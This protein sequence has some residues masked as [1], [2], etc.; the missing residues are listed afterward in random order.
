MRLDAVNQALGRRHIA[1]T[2]SIWAIF[3]DSRRRIHHRL[4][5]RI[6]E[7]LLRMHVLAKD[8]TA[9][10]AQQE[11]FNCGD[12]KKFGFRVKKGARPRFTPVRDDAKGHVP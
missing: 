6:N 11:S 7:S 8:S 1:V 4:D 3:L 2:K 5:D 10:V 12:A 9:E